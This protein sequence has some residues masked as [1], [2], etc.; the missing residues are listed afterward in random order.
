MFLSTL[1]LFSAALASTPVTFTVQTAD[2]APV[3]S[4]ELQLEG[5]AKS[6]A[7]DAA[8]GTWTAE[9]ATLAD[10]ETRAFAKKDV[11]KLSVT[12]PGY[13]PVK[14]AYVV[15]KKNNQVVIRLDATE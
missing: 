13:Q 8:T 7:V 10:G 2:G 4:A 1:V 5:E 12:A 6:H 3:P 14:V 11:L 9:S 15:R